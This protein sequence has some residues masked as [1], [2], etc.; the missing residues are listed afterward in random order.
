[1]ARMDQAER[2]L[3][4]IL[5]KGP[6]VALSSQA[7]SL[8]TLPPYVKFET[9]SFAM[10]YDEWRLS[11]PDE[12]PD[13]EMIECDQCAGTGM[14]LRDEHDTGTRCHV[15]GGS[16]EVPVEAEEPDS[17]YFYERRRDAAMDRR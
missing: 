14:H 16:G 1:M 3:A 9:E 10:T 7:G 6:K 13:T 17:D 2:W 5:G 12:Q 8:G 15:C 11:G 4:A